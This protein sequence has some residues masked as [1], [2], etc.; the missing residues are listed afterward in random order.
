MTADRIR[1][2]LE[3]E[4]FRPFSLRL[5]DGRSIEVSHPE[6]V[7]IPP[8]PRPREVMFSAV[9]PDDDEQFTT[10]WIDIALV[11]SLVIEPKV[12]TP[13]ENGGDV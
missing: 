4:P 1:D 6:F 10:H 3:R 8:V 11:V 9:V 2:A 5:V 7:F 12:A 13:I